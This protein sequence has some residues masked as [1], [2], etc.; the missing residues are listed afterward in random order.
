M[1][2]ICQFLCVCMLI[3]FPVSAIPPPT[4]APSGYVTA[5][6]FPGHWPFT[7]QAGILHCFPH[8]SENLITL[9]TDTGEY[10]LNDAAYAVYERMHWSTAH[11]ILPGS[12][13]TEERRNLVDPFVKQAL[14]LCTAERIELRPLYVPATTPQPISKPVG[15]FL[16]TI[17]R[18]RWSKRLDPNPYLNVKPDAMYLWI[19]LAIRNL[20]ME[21]RLIPPLVLLDDAGARYEPTAKAILIDEVI[22]PLDSLNPHVTKKGLVIFDV[23]PQMHYHLYVSGGYGS[24]AFATFDLSPENP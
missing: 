1:K 11:I 4:P 8:G 6:M 23:P 9:K 12:P 10:A 13:T 18:S 20:D 14:A 2:F 17:G 15:S 5:S 3:V 19:A 22:S 21:P 7:V 16:Y 24:E